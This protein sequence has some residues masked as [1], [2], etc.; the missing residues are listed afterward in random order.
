M[1]EAC[2]LAISHFYLQISIKYRSHFAKNNLL[3][4]PASRNWQLHR[5]PVIMHYKEIK[6]FREF[7]KAAKTVMVVVTANTQMN[8]APAC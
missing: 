2:A 8:A 7:G 5:T 1:A 4:Q 6:V 3:T